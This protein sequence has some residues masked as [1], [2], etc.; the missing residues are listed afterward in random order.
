MNQKNTYRACIGGIILLILS[1]I[2][3][4]SGL[5]SNITSAVQILK[6]PNAANIF[7][8][9]ASVISTLLNSGVMIAFTLLLTL[10]KRDK[11]LALVGLGGGALIALFRLIMG[12]INLIS[13]I[14]STP[15]LIFYQLVVLLNALAFAAVPA[16]AGFLCSKAMKDPGSVGKMKF[17]PAIAYLASILLSILANVAVNLFY[18]SMGYTAIGAIAITLI[19]TAFTT[20]IGGAVNVVCWY[21]IGD[22]IVAPT[23]KKP[24]A[25]KP[26][27]QPAQGYYPPQQPTYQAPQQNAYQAPTYQAPNY[28]AP[29]QNNYQPPQQ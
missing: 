11:T 17:L 21:L 8:V 15:G 18:V 4:I 12:L 29:Q 24:A 20:L 13:T 6:Y 25:K 27:Q 10:K 28:Q 19:T 2:G 26:V 22:W 5:A 1:I 7:S 16:S 3:L 23:E 14:A 9:I